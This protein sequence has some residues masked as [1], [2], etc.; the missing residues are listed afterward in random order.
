MKSYASSTGP[1]SSCHCGQKRDDH[2]APVV[3][4]PYVGIQG[5]QYFIEPTWPQRPLIMFLF[6]YGLR[7]LGPCAKTLCFQWRLYFFI[8]QSAT[9]VQVLG[10][11]R[12]TLGR[13]LV[14][15]LS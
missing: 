4:G 12:L 10:V 5:W 7:D 11:H 3:P 15:H 6:L 9:N 2:L 8:Q 13:T 1:A 14:V